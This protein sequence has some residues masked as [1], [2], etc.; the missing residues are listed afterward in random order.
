MN[1]EHLP[2]AV[3]M[4]GILG[5]ITLADLIAVVA[6]LLGFTNLVYLFIKFYN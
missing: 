3:G 2:S 6:L 1:S 5:T 4:A